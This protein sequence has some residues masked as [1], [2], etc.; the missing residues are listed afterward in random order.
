MR[1]AVLSVDKLLDASLTIA[2][3]DLVQERAISSHQ[4]YLSL[5]LSS[6]PPGSLA[7][8]TTLLRSH[9]CFPAFHG[10]ILPLHPLLPFLPSSSAYTCLRQ[11]YT[12]LAV[13]APTSPALYLELHSCGSGI[14]TLL[15]LS[16][17]HLAPLPSLMP[18]SCRQPSLTMLV[19]STHSE[20][21]NRTTE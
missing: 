21:C 13:L 4:T 5:L 18:N 3:A 17:S 19:S 10:P 15:C 16:N 2:C 20:P 9:S 1:L 6:P 11:P 8:G 14:P 12:C 7:P